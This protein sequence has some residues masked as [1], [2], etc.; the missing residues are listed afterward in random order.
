MNPLQ[1]PWE[2]RLSRSV[3]PSVGCWSPCLCRSD[4]SQPCGEQFASCAAVARGAG[5]CHRVDC[6]WCSAVRVGP[7]VTQR[8]P[9][10]CDLCQTTQAAERVRHRDIRKRN[11]TYTRYCVVV[12]G[13]P[14]TWAAP[15]RGRAMARYG[16]HK[17][18]DCSVYKAGTRTDGQVAGSGLPL[19]RDKSTTS[20]VACVIGV[21]LCA[22][23][24]VVL[25]PECRA[26]PGPPLF[27]TLASHPSIYRA[28]RDLSSLRHWQMCGS[29]TAR[30]YFF[31]TGCPSEP[32][33]RAARTSM[34]G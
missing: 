7:R 29:G 21:V 33:R 31:D 18:Y 28:A 17:A 22:F 11:Q 15:F 9:S 16:T 3:C 30:G 32:L 26:K 34:S 5:V 10:L 20:L 12:I 19:H 23:T 13:K 24:I 14:S 2:K 25:S 4:D 8:S 27:A 1:A 6:R